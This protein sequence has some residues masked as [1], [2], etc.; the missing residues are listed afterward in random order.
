M[1]ASTELEI[2][3][4]ITPT[5]VA[6]LQNWG[7]RVMINS[8]ESPC[9]TVGLVRAGAAASVVA[10]NDFLR[11]TLKDATA[12]ADRLFRTL[13]SSETVLH[14]QRDTIRQLLEDLPSNR[15]WLDPVLE[16]RLNDI[17]SREEIPS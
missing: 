14:Y 10:Q 15:D 6:Q 1:T 2:L 5:Q 13:V 17:V 7:G 11:D 4:Y 3:G 9:H 16:K 12:R 8:E